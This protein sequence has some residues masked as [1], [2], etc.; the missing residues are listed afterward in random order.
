[1][2]QTYTYIWNTISE[3]ALGILERRCQSMVT[4]TSNGIQYMQTTKFHGCQMHT[5]KFRGCHG[6]PGTHANAPS[7]FY[8]NVK[9]LKI[10]EDLKPL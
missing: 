8:N 5:S 7:E 1:M 9:K 2:L 3:G 10:F 4:V 6:I